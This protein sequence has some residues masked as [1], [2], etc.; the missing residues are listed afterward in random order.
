MCLWG[1]ASF[2]HRVFPWRGRPSVAVATKSLRRC[3]SRESIQNFSPWI[4]KLCCGIATFR[5]SAKETICMCRCNIHWG[6][7]SLQV[8]LSMVGLSLEFRAAS[9][10]GCCSTPG[11][12]SWWGGTGNASTTACSKPCLVAASIWDW[13]SFIWRNAQTHHLLTD[14]RCDLLRCWQMT[15]CNGMIRPCD[16]RECF[17]EMCSPSPPRKKGSGYS[18]PSCWTQGVWASAT[19]SVCPIFLCHLWKKLEKKV[20]FSLVSVLT[21]L[22]D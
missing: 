5:Y 15:D 1:S 9:E 16:Q 21:S 8:V 18:S 2:R 22:K 4:C 11:A 6:Q 7:G 14:E 19:F 13:R 3:E 17:D 20:R 10:S 12:R